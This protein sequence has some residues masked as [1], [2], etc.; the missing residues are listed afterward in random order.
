MN[1][2]AA[3]TKMN[4]LGNKII[5][6]DMRG[7]NDRITS[8]AART[9]AQ[10]DETS[11][12]QIMAIHDSRHKSTNYFIEIWNSDGSLAK[13]C[14]NGARCVAE[15]LYNKEK[16][17][18]FTFDTAG[19][20]VH[21]QRLPN[22]LVSV[23]MGKPRCQWTEIPLATAVE[24]TNHVALQ[25]G[26]LADAVVVSMGNPHAIFFVESSVTDYN[27]EDYGPKLEHNPLFPERANISIAHVTSRKSLDLRTWERGAG[28]TH[29]CGTAACASV[30]AACR[31]NLTDR[32]V[33]VTLPGGKLSIIWEKNDHVL[34]TGPTEYEFSGLFDPET[35]RYTRS[36]E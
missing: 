3:M 28:L 8:E 16:C 13:A 22:G 35:G 34:L 27:L 7:R 30:V 33:M 31:Q 26:P 32:Q 15:W 10:T 23:D 36:Q 20:I 21:A 17:N 4:G 11:F 6:A 19:G 25:C 5:V 9:L 14:G 2:P 1:I 12:D 18:H 29:A 24:D